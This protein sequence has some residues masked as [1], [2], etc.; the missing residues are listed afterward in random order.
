MADKATLNALEKVFAAE[1]DDRLPF[2]SRA[3]IFQKLLDDGLL[4][5]M[6]RTYG[7]GPF[8]ATVS[9]YQLSH[10]GRLIYCTSCE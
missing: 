8:A 1:I 4:A 3:K 9:G 6:D 10:A 5:T 7:T 2:Q